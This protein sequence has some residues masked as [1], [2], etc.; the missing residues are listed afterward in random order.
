[1]NDMMGGAHSED[2][3]A[4]GVLRSAQ[5]CLSGGE[6]AEE[7]E[8]G[9]QRVGTI[10]TWRDASDDCHPQRTGDLGRFT[11]RELSVRH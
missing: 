8:M 4:F 5:A 7:E 9:L 6:K 2:P 3:Y 10:D 1:M 11:Q